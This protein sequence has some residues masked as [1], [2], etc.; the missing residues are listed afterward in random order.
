MKC[1]IIAIWYLAKLLSSC[2]TKIFIQK[3]YLTWSNVPSN[4]K[5]K[6]FIISSKILSLDLVL[7]NVTEKIDFFFYIH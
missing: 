2:S 7:F 3:A 6:C 1:L 4:S 5:H